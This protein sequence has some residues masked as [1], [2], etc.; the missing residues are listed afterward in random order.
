MKSKV[1]CDMN[2]ILILS[3]DKSKWKRPLHKQSNGIYVFAKKMDLNDCIKKSEYLL[4]QPHIPRIIVS[5]IEYF[6]RLVSSAQNKAM[7]FKKC[8]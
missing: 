4:I 7:Y 8:Q 3:S 6:N 1:M 5:S 2:H